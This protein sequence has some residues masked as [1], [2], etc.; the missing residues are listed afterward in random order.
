MLDRHWRENKLY[1]YIFFL[2]LMLFVILIIIEKK[3]LIL[4]VLI[5]KSGLGL[6]RVLNDIKIALKNKITITKLIYL[7]KEDE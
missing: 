3:R 1:S 6:R 7:Y 4:Y 5:Q 2:N